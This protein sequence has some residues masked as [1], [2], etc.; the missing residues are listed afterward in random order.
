MQFIQ[1]RAYERK[2]KCKRKLA[3]E[4]KRARVKRKILRARP[5][6]ET[7]IFRRNPLSLPIKINNFA[8]PGSGT[9]Y[10]SPP[11]TR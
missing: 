3:R 5:G 7:L 4:R 11:F 9:R 2:R 1:T 10:L 6:G 8:N